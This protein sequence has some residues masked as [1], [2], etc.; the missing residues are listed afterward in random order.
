[1]ALITVQE[2]AARFAVSVQS[3]YQRIKTGSLQHEVQGGVKYVVV[4]SV[5]ES[6]PQTK[7][8]LNFGERPCDE[9]VK[10]YKVLIKDQRRQIKYLQ[11]LLRKEEKRQDKNYNRLQVLFNLVSENKDLRRSDHIEAKLVKPKKKKKK[12]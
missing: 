1:M 4:A 3:V 2:Y 7:R 8:V 11:K 6:Q 9:V 12:K 5:E 10:G